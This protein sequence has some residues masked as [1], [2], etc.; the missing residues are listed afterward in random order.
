VAEP[1]YDEEG[2]TIYHG[3]CREVATNLSADVLVTDPPYGMGWSSG[4]NGVRGAC[5][6]AGDADTSVR[7]DVLGWWEPRPAIV[8]G[9]W[10]VARPR[11]VRC[12]LIWEKGPHVGA[13]DLSLPWKP[14]H[15]EIYVM[16]TGFAG[17]RG[18]GVLRHNAPPPNFVGFRQ[19]P[20]EKPVALMADLVGKCPT[21]T[22]LDPFMG[23]GTT[24]VAAK[25]LGRRAI[26]I[27]IEER[28]CAIAVERLRQTVLRFDAPQNEHEPR[29][30]A[31]ISEANP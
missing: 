20:T 2:I 28:Y 24:L 5:E 22:V 9:T 12:V 26:G 4:F 17:H 8:F 6:V 10:K 29:Q 13:G 15:E 1:Y 19:H 16:G 30:T 18:S 23:S 7:D 31:L 21:G 27:E 11:N 3:D 25:Q 14:N